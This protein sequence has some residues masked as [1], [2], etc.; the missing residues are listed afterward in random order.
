MD[1]RAS[2]HPT[3]KAVKAKIRFVNGSSGGTLVLESA[4]VAR[5]R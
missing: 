3:V 2:E 5:L 4:T 1:V